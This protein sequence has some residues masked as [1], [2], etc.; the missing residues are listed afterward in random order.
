MTHLN[1]QS[2]RQ[3][4]RRQ[5]RLLDPRTQREAA[6]AVAKLCQSLPFFRQARRIAVYLANDGELDPQPL[7]HLC[8]AQ[9]KALYLPVLHPFCKGHLLFVRYT[10]D[11]PMT[12]NRF[13]IAEPPVQVPAICPL[14]ELDVV[15]TPLVGFDERGNRMGM[16]G[17]FYDRTLAPVH[18]DQLK[19]RII[20]LA[21][22][23]QRCPELARQPWDVALH[24]V[25]TPTRF[26]SC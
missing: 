20:G 3:S 18:R 1:S 26:Y 6:L 9:Q 17:G 25:L 11:T 23:C 10:Q 24:G 12:A 16:G 21:H 5:R 2:L 14:S 19:T 13:G 15:F 7:I 22:D 4:L 8:W